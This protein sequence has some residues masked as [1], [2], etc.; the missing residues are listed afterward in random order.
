MAFPGVIVWI[1]AILLRIHIARQYNITSGGALLEGCTGFWCCCCSIAQMARH[2]YGYTK[3][4]DGDSDP[5]KPDT[6][7]HGPV[8]IQPGNVSIQSGGGAAPRNEGTYY[9][10]AQSNGPGRV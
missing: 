6:Y 9:P 7:Y 2:V 4:F 1:F 10:N 8:Q 3:V 5:D